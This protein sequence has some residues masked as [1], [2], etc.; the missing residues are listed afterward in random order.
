MTIAQYF[1]T[2]TGFPP[3]QF[4]LQTIHKLLN[5]QDVLLRAPTGSGKTE[6]AIAPF[7]F[8]KTLQRD[9][10][11]KLIYVVP[12]RTLANSLRQRAET[13]ARTWETFTPPSRPL[14]VTLQTGENPEDPRF[15]GDIVF[16]TID[17]MLSSFLNIPYSVGVLPMLTLGRFLP[18]IWSLTNCTYSTQSVPLLPSAVT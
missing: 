15:E 3:R 13:L 17:Q 16:C 1:Q 12:L 8:A 9:F 6:T 11:N 18:P 5:R 7:L 4:Q 2:L 10:P 14:V